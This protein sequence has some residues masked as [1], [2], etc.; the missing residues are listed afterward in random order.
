LRYIGSL[1]ADAH[2][3]LLYG[4]VLMYPATTDDPQGEINIFDAIAISY[5]VE[6]AWG[7]S[8][9]GNQGSLLSITPH[10]MS[11]KTTLFL[12]T[13]EEIVEL[14]NLFLKIRRR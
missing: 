6:K 11:N 1:V 2:R 7:K 4:G 10:E 3:T 8:T 12:G 5:V 13:T 9:A 14:E